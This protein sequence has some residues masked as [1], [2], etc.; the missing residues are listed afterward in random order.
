MFELRSADSFLFN[1]F[2]FALFYT[3]KELKKHCSFSRGI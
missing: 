1:V 3:D 2:V